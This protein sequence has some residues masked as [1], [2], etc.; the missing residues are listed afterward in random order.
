MLSSRAWAGFGGTT[1]HCL[2]SLKSCL[3]STRAVGNQP[4]HCSWYLKKG[5]DLSELNRQSGVTLCLSLTFFIGS[6]LVVSGWKD[7]N[8]AFFSDQQW[9]QWWPA[10]AN[11]STAPAPIGKTLTVQFLL[12]L[13]WVLTLTI[14]SFKRRLFCLTCWSIRVTPDSPRLRLEETE[15]LQTCLNSKMAFFT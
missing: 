9:Q 4:A 7:W 13:F 3:T 15:K 11:R 6:Q 8:L 1:T 10:F 2:C 12:S 14:K 5:L